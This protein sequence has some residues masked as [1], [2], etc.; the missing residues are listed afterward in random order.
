MNESKV[1]KVLKVLNFWG[2]GRRRIFDAGPHPPT[3]LSRRAGRGGLYGM[4]M[5]AE[6][7]VAGCQWSAVKSL[8]NSKG[9]KSLNFLGTR[10]SRF[11]ADSTRRD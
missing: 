11:F 2:T 1:L 4:D 7:H 10:G 5:I 6:F 8:K 3:P 9:L